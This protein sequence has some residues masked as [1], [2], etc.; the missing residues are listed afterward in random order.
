VV[1]VCVCVCVVTHSFLVG[2]GRS[3]NYTPEPGR[4]ANCRELLKN[5]TFEF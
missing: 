1:C 2:T 5:S 3:L 4:F